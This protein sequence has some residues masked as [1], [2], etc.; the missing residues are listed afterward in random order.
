M[1]CTPISCHSEAIKIDPD[2]MLPD[3]YRTKFQDLVKNFDEV[4]S[5]ELPGYKDALDKFEATTCISMGPVQP[6]KE[7][8]GFPR[9]VAAI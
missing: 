7:R 9:T 8:A 6:L 2:R 1:N 5:P 3:S 4:F